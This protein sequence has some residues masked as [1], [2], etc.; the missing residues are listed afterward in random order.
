M[1]I[2]ISANP[3]IDRRIRL[4]NLVPGGVNRAYSAISFAGGK[5]AHVAMAAHALGEKVVWIGFVGGATGN[6]L[7]RQLT[8]FGIAALS[9]PTMAST[10]TNDEIVADDGSITEILEPG[11]PITA[12]EA[13]EFYAIA[14]KQFTETCTGFQVVIS[15]SLPPGAP[16]EFYSNI[17]SLAREFHARVIVDTS[18]DAF[19]KS[20]EHSPDLIKPNREETESAVGFEIGGTARTLSAIRQ[21]QNLGAREAA[22]SLGADGLVWS[23]GEA[24]FVVRPPKVNV[25]STVGCGDAAVAGFAVG[26]QRNLEPSEI[27]RLAAACG[28]ANCIA[29]L[30]GQIRLDDVRH[31]IPQVSVE[32]ITIAPSR[33]GSAF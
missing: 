8:E 24:A 9:I 18:G 30:P 17:I 12:A 22:I 29:E 23:D 32:K 27:V 13:E 16:T 2:C 6:E 26:A 10:R 25:I 7:E 5:A 20:L 19:L 21:L 1:I 28:A 4:R 11:G 31:L 14:R 15:G 3:A 33:I